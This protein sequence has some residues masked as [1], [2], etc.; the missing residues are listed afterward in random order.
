[1]FWECTIPDIFMHCSFWY[2]TSRDITG[3]HDLPAIVLLDDSTFQLNAQQKKYFI[4]SRYGHQ[5]DF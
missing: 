5:K 3:P 2:I 1:M 4:G